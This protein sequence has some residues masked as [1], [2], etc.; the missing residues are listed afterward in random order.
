MKLPE[1]P[2]KTDLYGEFAEGHTDE[3][4]RAYGKLC[5]ELGYKMGR[6]D[7]EG[8]QYYAAAIRQQGEPG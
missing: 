6:E 7:R 8:E 2:E 5:F 3:A 4:M 1:M